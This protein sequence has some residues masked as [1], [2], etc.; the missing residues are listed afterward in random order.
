MRAVESDR[1]R[2][3]IGEA[4][5]QLQFH[6][7]AVRYWVRVGELGSRPGPGPDEWTIG[8]DDLVA[9][10]RQNGEVPPRSL[11]GLGEPSPAILRQAGGRAG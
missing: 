10:L 11:P 6:P 2:Y 8:L 1:R 3:T 9:F 7:D 5:A 4:A